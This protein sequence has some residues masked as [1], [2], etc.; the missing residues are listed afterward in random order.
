SAAAH[1]VVVVVVVF[2]AAVVHGVDHGLS[3]LAGLD[4]AVQRL[5]AAVVFPVRQH[6]DRL[7]AGLLLGDLIAG[8]EDAV[9]EQRAIACATA[10][11]ALL[12]LL[13][14]VVAVSVATGYGFHRGLGI[15]LPYCLFQ[16]GVVR[17]QVLQQFHF[18]IKVD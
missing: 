14:L 13:I 2:V 7:P 15:D 16:L 9:V 4:G 10:M 12:L 11:T 6:Y 3:S 18:A 5:L 17:R 8:E 1:I